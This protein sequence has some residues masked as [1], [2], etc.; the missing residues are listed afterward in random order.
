MQ[1]FLNKTGNW[2]SE[3]K[4]VAESLHKY[5]II[6]VRDPRV[7][8]KDNDVYIDMMEKYFN[9]VGEKFYNGEKLEDERPELSYQTGV[10]PEST[11]RARD[12][13]KLVADLPK[14]DMPMS[15]FPPELDAKWRF[16][17]AIGE[18]PSECKND[19]P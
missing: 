1:C 17:W 15:P 7:N 13:A 10:T 4:K 9:S 18:R 2:E 12:H 16:F 11:E 5:G 3:C 8:H 6:I 14:E 19:I